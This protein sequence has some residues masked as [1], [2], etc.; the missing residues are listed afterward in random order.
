MQAIRKKLW[1]RLVQLYY[2]LRIAID[3]KNANKNLIIIPSDGGICSQIGFWSLGLFYEKSG[4]LVKYDLSWFEQ[5][6]MD[7]DNR[8]VRNYDLDKIFPDAV[9]PVASG[10]ECFALR[11]YHVDGADEKFREIA[12]PAFVTGYPNRESLIVQNRDLIRSLFKLREEQ[13]S[14]QNRTILDSIN[15]C[16]HACAIHVR[17]G[18][19]A[20]DSSSYGPALTPKY[21][22]AAIQSILGKHKEAH[23]FFFSDELSWVQDNI[24]PFVKDQITYTLVADNGSDKGYIDLFLMSKCDSFVT[25]QG[26]LGK[27]ARLLGADD[28]LIVEPSSRV[29]F[30]N[31]LLE[32]VIVI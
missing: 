22:D 32:N 24:I 31:E 1:K 27:Y 30:E 23:F 8:F 7:M 25:S 28:A 17:R 26:S 11:K 10:Y 15:G 3:G 19:L 20:K 4:F 16:L 2:R 14:V 21:F 18:D 13:L 12:P 29:M 6:G 9:L 5:Y